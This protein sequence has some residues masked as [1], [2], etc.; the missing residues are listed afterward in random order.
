MKANFSPLFED[1]QSF[2]SYDELAFVKRVDYTVRCN[3]KVFVD[4]YLDG[5]YHVPVL[6]KDLT[7]TIDFSSYQTQVE[8]YFS[9][10][11]VTGDQE[12]DE[13]I[14]KGAI[15]LFMYPNFMINRSWFLKNSN[16]QKMKSIGS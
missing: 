6:H 13:R 16:L 3:W 2:G 10:Q 9:V 15:Y 5:G 14:G 11:R 1:L 4:N 7:E 12:Q 8:E